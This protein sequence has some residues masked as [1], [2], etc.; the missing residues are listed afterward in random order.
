MIDLIE[1]H[2][3]IHLLD[4][5][6]VGIREVD[7]LLPELGNI[8]ID[9]YDKARVFTMCQ[10]SELGQDTI[11]RWNDD[12]TA[13]TLSED[14]TDWHVEGGLKALRDEM[15]AGT[16]QFTEDT[17]VEAA[18]LVLEEKGLISLPENK[19]KIAFLVWW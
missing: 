4:T 9:Q 8:D 6:G 15:L 17:P 18:L 16:H 7:K 10:R 11:Y 5:H 19:S 1:D 14:E 3:D 13:E 12:I 2:I